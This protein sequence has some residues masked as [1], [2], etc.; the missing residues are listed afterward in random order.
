MKIL[1][2]ELA[3]YYPIKIAKWLENAFRRFESVY[4]HENRAKRRNASTKFRKTSES[5][6]AEKIFSDR[7]VTPLRS[8]IPRRASR[9]RAPV[10]LRRECEPALVLCTSLVA[11]ALSQPRQKAPTRVPFVLSHNYDL[12]DGV[13]RS[14]DYMI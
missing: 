13:C 7:R 11:S 4:R 6:K 9:E 5:K 12:D 14:S 3:N 10:G 8:V 2:V 1:F